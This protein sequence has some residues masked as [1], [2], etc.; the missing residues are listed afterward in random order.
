ALRSG[1][2]GVMVSLVTAALS[3]VA[4]A[5]SLVIGLAGLL[6][7]APPG[8]DGHHVRGVIRL[9]EAMTAAITALFA[10]AALV[11]TADLVR[12]WLSRRRA[13]EPELERVVE[14][15]RVPTWL[16]ILTQVLSLLNLAVLGYLV[17]RGVSPLGGLL[18]GPGLGSGSFGFS[19]GIPE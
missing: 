7:T 18:Q 11:C 6:Q 2:G 10:L 1:A 19:L 16:R 3:W 12:R 8:A 13:A 15:P 14:A 5:V 17:W 9:P 4:L